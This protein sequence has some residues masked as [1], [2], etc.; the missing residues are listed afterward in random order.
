MTIQQIASYA[1]GQWIAPGAGARSIKS[2]ITGEVIASAGNNALDVEAMLHHART[3]GGPALRA[4]TFHQRAKMLKALAQYI[5]EHKQAL[6]DLSFNT[7]AT[8]SDGMIDID[9]GIGTMFVFAS[10]G[11]RDM[12]DGHVYVDGEP[13][14]FT[15]TGNFM[16]QHI[17]TPL[18]GVAVHINA[19]NFP[20][21]GMLEK[22][23]PTFLAGVPAIVK[24][25][26][27][28]CYLTEACV[29]L[30]LQSGIL[31]DGALQF[32]AGGLGDMLERLTYQ[33]VVSFTGSADTAHM[34]RSNDHLLRNSVRFMAEQDSLNASI[35][36]PDAAPGTP[37]FDLFVKEVH[38]EMT[39]KA[40]QK[41]TAI[42]RII[43]PEA[44]VP[45]LIEALS[46]RLG[47]TLIGDPRSEA[48]RMGALVSTA[49][50][51]DVLEKAALIGTEAERVFGDPNAFTVEGA[52]AVKGA[53]LTPMLFHCA[54]PDAAQ[55]VHDTEAF[56]PVSTIMGYRD[57][58]H[59]IDL[60]NR[61]GGSLVASVITHDPSVAREVAMG[62]AAHHGRLYFNNRDSMKGSTGHGSPLPH[63]VHGGPGRAG[64][65]EEMGGVRGVMHYMQR[66]AIQGSPDILTGITGQWVPGAKE[67]TAPAHPFTR[68]YGEL[69][70]GE[71]LNTAPRTVTL[72]D[73]EHFAHFTGDTFYAHMDD[74]A[75]KRNPF[76]PGRVAHGYLLLS[77][78]AGLFV[79]PNEG[80]VLANTGLDTLRFMKPVQA[81]DAI[82]VRL[83]VKKKTQRTGEYGEVKWHVT[84]TNQDDDTVAEYELLT[85]NAY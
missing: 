16:G 71:T 85:M 30:M 14:S 3:V 10:K 72:D 83:T 65:G 73:I 48:T 13:E 19:F 7:G 12:P 45:A 63:L 21:W 2:A 25:A 33:D 74:D 56:G 60:V 64:G 44:Q 18:Q 46:D 47:K 34:L 41:C 70:I 61:G 69:S 23:A 11:R 76:F 17:C 51:A 37:E 32:V 24:P 40:G 75:A 6:Y 81:G 29:R 35:L 57:L 4:M 49:Q 52:D 38:R 68:T 31:P 50:R 28:T 27:A 84:L 20:V 59:A 43:A 53:F 78:A 39:A 22:L 66:T 67:I 5:G 62:A 55:R 15:K 9:G 54:Y 8:Q 80:P 42:R 79:E 26:T 1:A 77:F 58:G 36:G 82:K